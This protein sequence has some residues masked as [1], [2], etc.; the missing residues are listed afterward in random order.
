MHLWLIRAHV[1]ASTEGSIILA[2]VVLKLSGVAFLKA[3]F[4][5]NIRGI[6]LYI[7]F[8]ATITL[9]GSFFLTIYILRQNDLKLIVAVSSVVHI[10]FIFLIY[11]NS[12]S[13]I[14]E[15]LNLVIIAHG[16]ISPLIFLFLGL[17]YDNMIRRNTIIIRGFLKSIF[18]ASI[19]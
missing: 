8:F 19:I 7:V 11:L 6:Q 1:E 3:I 15:T 2:R 4:N 14:I 12:T 10:C 18:F 17:H 5:I 9:T 13:V 16:L